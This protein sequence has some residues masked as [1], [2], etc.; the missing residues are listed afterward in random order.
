VSRWPRSAAGDGV[1]TIFKGFQLDVGF[2]HQYM[3][4]RYQLEDD[5]RGFFWLQSCGALLEVSWYSP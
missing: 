4:V 5:R 1:E 3:D 2:P